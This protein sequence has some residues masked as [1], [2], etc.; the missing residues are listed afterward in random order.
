ML[1]YAIAKLI[2]DLQDGIRFCTIGTTSGRGPVLNILALYTDLHQVRVR[3][4]DIFSIVA[5]VIR[6]YFFC[7]R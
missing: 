6:K 7:Q 4:D 3:N 1:F 2:I 5:G